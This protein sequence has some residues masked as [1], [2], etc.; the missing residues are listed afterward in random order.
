MLIRGGIGGEIECFL[1]PMMWVG[2]GAVLRGEKTGVAWKCVMGRRGI[3]PECVPEGD[4]NL[5][6]GTPLEC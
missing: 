6:K 3:E 5:N 2:V 4:K 1:T